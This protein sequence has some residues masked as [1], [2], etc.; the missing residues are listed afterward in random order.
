MNNL[1]EITD[2]RFIVF[3]ERFLKFSTEQLKRIRDNIDLVCF[4]TFNYDEENK[5]FCPVAIALNLHKTIENPTNV[6]VTEAMREYFNPP[7][8]LKGV[9]G[10]FYTLN[11]REDLL[12]AI[13][14]FLSLKEIKKLLDTP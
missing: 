8:A 3:C 6:L 4:D 9:K 10:D 14:I 2:A 7:N 5:K 11:R 13:D 1:A 12:T